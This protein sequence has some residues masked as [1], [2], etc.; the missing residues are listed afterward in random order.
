MSCPH[1]HDSWCASAA[2]RPAVREVRERL[3][4]V[5]VALVL[6]VMVLAV[7]AVVAVGVCSGREVVSMV[8]A[9]WCVVVGG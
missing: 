7:V 3:V 6:A 1:Q 2:G 4:T 5:L 9:A 8:L